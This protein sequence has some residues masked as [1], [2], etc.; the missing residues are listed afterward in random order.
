[1]IYKYRF[2]QGESAVHQDGGAEAKLCDG[3]PEDYKKL[4]L[5]MAAKFRSLELTEEE[6]Q[7]VNALLL[8]SP[9]KGQMNGRRRHFT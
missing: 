3:M 1:M 2:C 6:M 8:V 4:V 5:Q 9:G 7:L